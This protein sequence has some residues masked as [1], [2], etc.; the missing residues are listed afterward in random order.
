MKEKK[1]FIFK[2][3]R[4]VCTP[5]FKLLYRYEITNRQGTVYINSAIYTVPCLL[6]FLHNLCI[7]VNDVKPKLK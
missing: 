5:L 6:L 1:P 4:V 7:V 3:A 2:L